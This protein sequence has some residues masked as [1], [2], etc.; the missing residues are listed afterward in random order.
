MLF[1]VIAQGN[2]SCQSSYL[3]PLVVDDSVEDEDNKIGNKNGK[4]N[5][6]VD[7]TL[8]AQCFFKKSYTTRKK[9]NKH[10]K[11]INQNKKA[12]NNKMRFFLSHGNKNK[13]NYHNER[14]K[15]EKGA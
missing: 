8:Y 5:N 9:K 3:F 4:V 15:N 14:K 13:I 2:F 11:N 10:N 6:E 12:I 7:C 1:F